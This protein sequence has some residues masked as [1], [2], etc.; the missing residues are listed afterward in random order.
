MSKKIII[1]S[2]IMIMFMASCKTG[3][4]NEHKSAK[5]SFHNKHLLYATLYHHHAAERD[6]LAFQAF[7]IATRVVYDD[8]KRMGL[9]KQ[10]AIIVDIDETLL[11]NSPYEAVCILENISYPEKWDEWMEFADAKPLPGAVEFLTFATRN[12]YEV[13]YVTNRKEKY[14]EYTLQNLK[15][16]QFPISSDEN[17]LMRNS[18]RSKESRRRSIAKEYDILM[19]IGDNLEDLSVVFEKQNSKERKILVDS[20]SNEFGNR[21]IVLPNA[22]YGSWVDALYESDRPDEE[23]E[24][25]LKLI[26]TLNGF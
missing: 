8:M 24:A 17:L 16:Y 12:G 23:E 5:E 10:Q 15:K 22:M 11:D 20:L 14:R 7:N 3:M 19:L 26:N 18:E 21:F 4:K 2:G 6:A 13:F 25:I 1:I 9:S